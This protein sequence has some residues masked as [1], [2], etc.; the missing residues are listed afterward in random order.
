MQQFFIDGS[1][2]PPE[3]ISRVYD[4][5]ASF[6]TEKVELSAREIAERLR[7]KNEMAVYSSLVILEKAGHIER[8]RAAGSQLLCRSKLSVDDALAAAPDDSN[9][10]GVLR[11]LIFTRNINQRE[12]AELDIAATGAALGLTDAQ[13]KKAV[14]QLA[15]RG[16]LECRNAFQGRG[17]RLLDPQPAK[18]LR[19]DRQE[20]AA[21]ASAE[22]WK[23]RR[24]V[25]YCYHQSCLRR[26]ILNYFGDRKP[27]TRCEACSSCSPE[28][29]RFAD[30]ANRRKTQT[31][32][33]ALGAKKTATERDRFIIE[34]AP[35]GRE[36]RAEL[37]RKAAES[38]AARPVVE[39]EKRARSLTESETVVVKKILSCV[40]RINDRFGKGTVALVLAGSASRQVKENNLDRLST[41]GLLK[42]MTKDEINSYIKALIDAGCI[43][44]SSGAYPTVGLTPMG[45]EVMTGRAEVKLEI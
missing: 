33:L 27:L 18:A 42:E 38:R 28:T 23:L 44:V 3:I 19:I 37:K 34:S 7:I 17:I 2:P 43:K 30:G 29:S 41:Y 35:T 12:P 20:L 22:Q 14:S 13:V 6:G 40:A 10:G 16:I 11:D 4:T 26:F 24:I 21:R 25:D 8:G 15:A 45:R 36:L 1:H 32:T 5:I 9:E 31:G 39:E